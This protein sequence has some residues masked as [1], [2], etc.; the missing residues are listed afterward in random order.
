[1]VGT[2]SMFVSSR[3]ATPTCHPPLTQLP[4]LPRPVIMLTRRRGSSHL[5]NQDPAQ[6]FPH[7]MMASTRSADIVYVVRCATLR[8]RMDVMGMQRPI[9]AISSEDAG[10]GTGVA[11]TRNRMSTNSLP[12]QRAVQVSGVFHRFVTVCGNRIPTLGR[13][14]TE[15]AAEAAPSES[16][17]V[18]AKPRLDTHVS[19]VTI[20][21]RGD[22]R[23]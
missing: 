13:T 4:S 1:M 23:T 22:L 20:A 12:S 11:V 17:A 19:S 15:G 3:D 10:Y 14:N 18:I 2:A 6:R 7:R 8:D 9:G 5:R 21:L 16:L